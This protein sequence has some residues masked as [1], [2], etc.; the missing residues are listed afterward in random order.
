MIKQ[1]AAKPLSERTHRTP[2]KN[3]REGNPISLAP[4][5]FDEAVR[6]M[7]ATEPPKREPK[8]AKP[9]KKTAKK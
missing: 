1:G 3:G 4:L 9:K 7:L 6:K 5:T 2:N 8:E